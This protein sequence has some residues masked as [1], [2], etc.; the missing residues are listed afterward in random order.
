MKILVATKNPGKAEEIKEFLGNGFKLVSLA[1]FS[2]SPDIEETGE[3]FEEN[4]LLKART[5][6]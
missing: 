2:N 5:Y 4:A 6:F 1:D 3:T